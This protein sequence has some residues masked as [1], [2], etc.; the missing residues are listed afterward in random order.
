MTQ[1]VSILFPNGK[2]WGLND[3]L[4]DYYRWTLPHIPSDK[5]IPT[6]NNNDKKI[7]PKIR[8]ETAPFIL[9][10]III[11]AALPSL[12][13]IERNLL[14]NIIAYGLQNG[15]DEKDFYSAGKRLSWSA[16]NKGQFLNNLFAVSSLFIAQR[17]N[18]EN[19]ARGGNGVFEDFDSMVE[20]VSES[21][22]DNY[23]G[24]R[25]AEKVNSHATYNIDDNL[26]T[27]PIYKN[28]YRVKMGTLLHECQHAYQDIQMRNLTELESESESYEI[29]FGALFLMGGARLVDFLE[30][31]EIENYEDG[32]S[33]IEN[34]Y[35]AETINEADND[36]YE[37]TIMKMLGMAD[38]TSDDTFKTWYGLTLFQE[39]D[40]N[41]SKEADL[42]ISDDFYC[43]DN[44]NAQLNAG[45]FIEKINSRLDQSRDE[46]YLACETSPVTDECLNNLDNYMVIFHSSSHFL[47]D[48]SHFVGEDGWND[49]YGN[50]YIGNKMRYYDEDANFIA[51]ILTKQ[52]IPSNGFQIN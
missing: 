28:Y 6:P 42:M 23:I 44:V 35:I 51:D 50:V 4:E 10:E 52:V 45:D 25:D 17:L 26:I 18:W 14:E 8:F 5:Y 41:V 13:D 48:L 16:G 21:I 30:I 32:H 46:M 40:L 24:F 7:D 34:R 12:N 19:I 47:L 49:L 43:A 11:D 3:A 20:A 36:W 38:V 9:D 31:E 27:T 39:E 1:D 29:E 37:K 15:L 22:F 2:A 33:W